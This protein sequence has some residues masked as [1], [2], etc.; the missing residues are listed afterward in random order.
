MCSLCNRLVLPPGTVYHGRV[1]GRLPGDLPSR[2]T[3]PCAVC[4]VILKHDRTEEGEA[5]GGRPP[6]RRPLDPLVNCIT[7]PQPHISC[8]H[9]HR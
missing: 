3:R 4:A 6:G 7:S 5:G 2:P 1:P 9:L 8:P